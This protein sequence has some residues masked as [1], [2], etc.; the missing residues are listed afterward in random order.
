MT[1]R[2]LINLLKRIESHHGG[3]LE[4]PIYYSPDGRRVERARPLAINGLAKSGADCLYQGRLELT[5]S[6]PE[7][8]RP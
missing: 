1:T 5:I 7:N 8:I 2:E 6:Y 3:E 4:L